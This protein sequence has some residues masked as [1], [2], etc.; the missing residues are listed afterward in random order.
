MEGAE[1]GDC[2]LTCSFVETRYV[3]RL[4]AKRYP[5]YSSASYVSVAAMGQD[6][7]GGILLL[8]HSMGG[9]ELARWTVGAEATVQ[10]LVNCFI[11]IWDT[12]K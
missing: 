10:V 8:C 4:C 11:K 12:L 5:E 7:E 2:A 9:N 6:D 3:C 1:A